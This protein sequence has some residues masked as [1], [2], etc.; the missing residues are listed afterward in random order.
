M[1]YEPQVNDYVIWS[2]REHVQGWVYFKDKNYVTIETQ[3]IPKHPQSYEDCT[4]HENNRV[5][6][7]CY[8]PQWNELNYVKSRSSKYER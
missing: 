5:L 3:V 4:I 1:K 2:G 6:V 7:L 8:R